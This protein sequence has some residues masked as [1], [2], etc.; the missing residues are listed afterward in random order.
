M[1]IIDQ[2]HVVFLKDWAVSVNFYGAEVLLDRS[3]FNIKEFGD[4]TFM[5]E[6]ADDDSYSFDGWYKIAKEQEE[7]GTEV[8]WKIAS[9]R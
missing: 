2:T 5:V 9:E 3:Y 6:H 7:A 4:F 8:Q 1:L